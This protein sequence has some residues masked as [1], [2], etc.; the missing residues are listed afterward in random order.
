MSTP[1]AAAMASTRS[2][3]MDTPLST[4]ASS[5]LSAFY[6]QLEKSLQPCARASHP[7]V[8]SGPPLLQ[9]ARFARR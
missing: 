2:S 5:Q 3:S 9:R 4:A 7:D 6:H 1:R 8:M